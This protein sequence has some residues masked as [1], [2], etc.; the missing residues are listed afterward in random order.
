MPPVDPVDLGL[1]SNP[2]LEEVEEESDGAQGVE[3]LKAAHRRKRG[4]KASGGKNKKKKKNAD[5]RGNHTKI[6]HFFLTSIL[7]PTC[8]TRTSSSASPK[9]HARKRVVV[10]RTGVSDVA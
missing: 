7:K 3:D 8:T 6:L 5:V 9:K 2:V 4:G 1:G 10:P